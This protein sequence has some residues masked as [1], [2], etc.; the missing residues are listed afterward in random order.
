MN[1]F[2]WGKAHIES[3]IPLQE[4]SNTRL[5]QIS[6]ILDPAWQA[7]PSRVGSGFM[8]LTDDKME[9]MGGSD[10]WVMDQLPQA[11]IK[12]SLSPN[13]GRYFCRI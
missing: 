4:W 12:E 13:A 6:D 9:A 3:L 5:E 7:H 11:T 10:A 8:G 2:F 1:K